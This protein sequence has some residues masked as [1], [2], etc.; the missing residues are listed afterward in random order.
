MNFLDICPLDRPVRSP[1]ATPAAPVT[2]A[3]PARASDEDRLTARPDPG[4]LVRFAAQEIADADGRIVGHDLL[5]RWNAAMQPDALV[6]GEFLT[7]ALLANA[8]IDAGVAGQTPSGR[9]FIPMDEPTLMGPLAD[10]VTPTLGVIE[11]TDAV[12]VDT[13]VLMR[14]AQLRA[15]GQRFSIDGLRHVEDPRWLLAPYA[16]VLKLDLV[17]TRPA[18]LAPIVAR[19]V[20]AGLEVIGK[21]VESMA[22]YQ[23]LRELGVT[24]CQGR[25]ISPPLDVSVPALPGCDA[26]VL[27]RARRLLADRADTEAI[28]AE[29]STD[30]AIVM[31]LLIVAGRQCT[32]PPQ[33]PPTLAALLADW[34]PALLGGWIRVWLSACCHGHG[35]AWVRS[36]RGEVARYQRRL[37]DAASGAEARGSLWQ[38][39][40]RLCSPKHYLKTRRYGG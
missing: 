36:V 13:A 27:L 20:D 34:P 17:A 7:S 15:R 14:V 22:G 6:P 32:V 35:A 33:D 3:A 18:Q 16:D 10:L 24:Q 9:L 37:G 21:R 38:V 12:A 19:A 29:L 1:A 11:L 25:F 31:R 8:L 2:L 23:R 40:R 4:G 26:A 30:P 39:Q 5:F 28:A